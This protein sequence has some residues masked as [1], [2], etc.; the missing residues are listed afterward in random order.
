MRMLNALLDTTGAGWTMKHNTLKNFEM[1]CKSRTYKMVYI[2]LKTPVQ[3]APRS[4]ISVSS[5]KLNHLPPFHRYLYANKDF[6]YKIFP[7]C[8]GSRAKMPKL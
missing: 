6:V 5:P 8:L 2:Q 1:N 7:F 3:S 4:I